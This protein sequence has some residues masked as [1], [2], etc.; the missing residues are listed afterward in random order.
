M[1]DP[2]HN[3]RDR[4]YLVR[5]NLAGSWEGLDPSVIVVN[6]NFGK[7][8]DS[9]AFFANRG[10]RQI[11]AAYYDGPLERTRQ[12]LESAQRVKGVTGIMYTTWRNRYEELE[13]FAKIRTKE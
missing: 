1:F 12:W 2:Y 3:A 4:Y 11:I 5:G 9:L 7:R 8:D 10:H 6:W 13:A